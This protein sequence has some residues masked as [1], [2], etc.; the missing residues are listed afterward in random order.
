MLVTIQEK[1]LSTV[2]HYKLEVF[3]KILYK[4]YHSQV[5]YD[6]RKY[7]FFVF[8]KTPSKKLVLMLKLYGILPN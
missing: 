5:C 7:S 3:F 8:H 6:Y 4:N 1:L 2:Q